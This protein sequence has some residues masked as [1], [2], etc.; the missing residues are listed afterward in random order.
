MIYA[1]TC[2]SIHSDFTPQFSFPPPPSLVNFHAGARKL[3]ARARTQVRYLFVDSG[4]RFS[5]AEQ[6]A[7]LVINF[8]R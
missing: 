1:P 3:T 2:V 8:A 6:K 7:N 5:A 4:R